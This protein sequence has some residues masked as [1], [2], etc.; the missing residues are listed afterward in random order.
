MICATSVQVFLIHVFD[1]IL[2]SASPHIL[3]IDGLEV[4][5]NLKNIYMNIISSISNVYKDTSSV[6]L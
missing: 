2:L 6:D 5:K 3:L 4:Y 1:N